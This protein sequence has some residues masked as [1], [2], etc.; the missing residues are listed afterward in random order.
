MVCGDGPDFEWPDVGNA[1]LP[2]CMGSALDGPAG[3][4]CWRPVYDLD[5][6]EIT[7]NPPGLRATACPDCAYR[8]GSPERQGADHVVGDTD[9]LA[10]IV[11]LNRPFFCHQGMR[12]PTMFR[13]PS[14]ATFRPPDPGLGAAYRPPS[15][16]GVPYRADGTPADI[17]AGW[18][19]ARLRID[20]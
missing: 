8:G 2:C 11:D 19:T 5:Q 16:D 17:C 15:R 13:H 12:R 7:P 4:S 1:E 14:G 20:R 6:A 9:A 18:A 10:A 3:C